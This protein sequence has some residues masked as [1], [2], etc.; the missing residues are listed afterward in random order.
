[1]NEAMIELWNSRVTKADSVYILGDFAF[2]KNPLQV[3][4]LLQQLKGKK[5][6]LRGN[7]DKFV[8][9]PEFNSGLFEWI[10]DYHRMTENKQR[11]ILCHYPIAVW[12]CSHRGAIHLYGHVHRDGFERHPQLYYLENAYN[13]CVSI[14]NY[15]PCTLEEIIANNKRF[16]RNRNLDVCKEKTI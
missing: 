4:E 16:L 6:L 11:L 5:Y 2:S 7:H 12:D 8:D 10:K 3:N 1:M 9:N 14:N 13:A 15:I